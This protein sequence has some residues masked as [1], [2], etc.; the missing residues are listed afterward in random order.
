[1]E[2]PMTDLSGVATAGNKVYVGAHNTQEVFEYAKTGG[3]YNL[4]NTITP[5]V[6]TEDFGYNVAVS[7]NWL[8][9]A[10]PEYGPPYPSGEGKIFMFQKQAD[11]SWAEHSIL[12]APIAGDHLGGDGIALKGDQLIATKRN[13]VFP[14]PGGDIEVFNLSGNTWI[15]TGTIHKAGYDW[16]SVDMDNSGDRIIGTGAINQ[17]FVTIFATFF[18]KTPS[19]WVEEDEVVITPP[20]PFSIVYPRD[21]AI[22]NGTA[23]L[24]AV[25]PGTIHWVLKNDGGDWSVDQEL[26]IP[27]D[28][29]ANRWTAMHG[30][31]ILIGV[32]SFA[33]YSSDKVYVF[34]KKGSAYNLTETLNPADEGADVIMSDLAMDGNTIVVGATR[35][36]G[37]TVPGKTYVFD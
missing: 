1:M 13:F 25:I 7:G 14:S 17:S 18:V 8:A 32:S 30:S 16:V 22:Q 29:I 19:G 5:S 34:K 37:T 35:A 3:T 9:V 6:P 33:S 28:V 21:V 15:S 36:A 4:V 20:N 24:T 31:N 11:G 12:T 26:K 2:S 10:A 27:A 23:V